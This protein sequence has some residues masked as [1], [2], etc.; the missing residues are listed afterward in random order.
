MY[1]YVEL[2]LA[3]FTLQ[4]STHKFRYSFFK[5]ITQGFTTI[6]IIIITIATS[7]SIIIVAHKT[8]CSFSFYIFQQ[9]I[10]INDYN[11]RASEIEEERYSI[12]FSIV[13]VENYIGTYEKLNHF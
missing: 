7:L 4:P 3:V 10:E 6:R 9:L 2:V 1:A 11:I 12:L 5:R 13:I 8:N